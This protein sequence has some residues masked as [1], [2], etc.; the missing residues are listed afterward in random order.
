MCRHEWDSHCDARF[1]RRC[2]SSVLHCVPYTTW[3]CVVWRIRW[4][5]STVAAVH[6]ELS[7]YKADTGASNVFLTAFASMAFYPHEIGTVGRVWE[8]C[9]VSARNKRHRIFSVLSIFL[10]TH[11]IVEQ[12]RVH[13]KFQYADYSHTPFDTATTQSITSRHTK[14][15]VLPATLNDG[16]FSFL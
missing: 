5:R 6:H 10:R 13:T 12:A 9:T 16:K 15:H 4:F 2:S 14:T 7:H 8:R 3:Y 1:R 11:A